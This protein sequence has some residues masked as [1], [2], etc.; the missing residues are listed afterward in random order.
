MEITGFLNYFRKFVP[1]FNS[2]CEPLYNLLNR[3][4]KFQWTYVHDEVLKNIKEIL[5]KRI[6]I[7]IPNFEKEFLLYTDAS[8]KGI[9]AILMQKENGEEKIIEYASR[10]LTKEEKNY[11]IAEKEALAIRWAVEHVQIFLKGNTF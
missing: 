11:A 10:S 6:F 5:N 1:N 7:S 3:N 4:T 8:T 2:I 9:G